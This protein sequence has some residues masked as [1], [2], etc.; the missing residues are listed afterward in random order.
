MSKI[1]NKQ[2]Q[3]LIDACNLLCRF[4]EE[5]LP[6]DWEIV[7]HMGSE[8]AYLDLI[9]PEGDDIEFSTADQGESTIA[10]LCEDAQFI[11][12]GEPA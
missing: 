6:A 10:G 3:E 2:H 8:E 1:T 7:L 11:E 4:V 9:N 5:N 12:S